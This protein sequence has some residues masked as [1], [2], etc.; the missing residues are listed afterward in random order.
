MSY[1]P[2]RQ[3]ARANPS[4][5]GAVFRG[6]IGTLTIML[7]TCNVRSDEPGPE[8]SQ[9]ESA[10]AKTSYN[11]GVSLYRIGQFAEAAD[12]FRK[13]SQSKDPHLA[14]MARYN[15]GNTQYSIALMQVQ[16]GQQRDEILP[17]IQQAITS[18]RSALRLAPDDDDARANLEL[19]LRALKQMQGPDDQDNPSQQSQDDKSQQ[20]QSQDNQSDQSQQ[21]SDQNQQ[22]DQQN[23]RDPD[24]SDQQD[25]DQQ[26]SETENEQTQ[27]D[28][29]QD[30]ASEQN[31]SQADP[32]QRDS[33]ESDTAEQS[34]QPE[35]SGE[36]EDTDSPNNSQQQPQ[37]QNN[38]EAQPNDSSST[39]SGEG[40]D[41]PPSNPPTDSSGKLEA[42]NDDQQR[43]DAE[44][45]QAAT[46]A[47][48]DEKLMTQQE[49]M[50]MLQAIRDRDMERRYRRERAERSRYIPV[51]RDW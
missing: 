25:A 42:A 18:Y 9:R 13:A 33:S 51:E 35:P 49:A 38:N 39:N 30:D 21:D 24:Q 50:K 41:P 2:K 47:Y 6:L 27:P 8:P 5:H 37:S 19:A 45:M 34:G 4:S 48:D 12:L 22:D 23:E 44:P 16:D 17:L 10:S 11:Q 20:N 15:L 29:N 31:D 46:G 40:D 43:N 14:A 7:W 32:Q 3:S 26:P 36:N 1:E 28:Q